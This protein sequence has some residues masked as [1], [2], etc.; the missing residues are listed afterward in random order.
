MDRCTYVAEKNDVICPICLDSWVEKDPRILQ[1]QHIFC[2]T[3]LKKLSIE[4]NTLYCPLCRQL[5]FIPEGKVKN[6]QKM[7]VHFSKQMINYENF[8]E[9]HHEICNFCCLTH[10]IEKI[11]KKC[12]DE[13][14]K[15]CKIITIEE[16]YMKSIMISKFLQKESKLK[17]QLFENIQQDKENLLEKIN[18]KIKQIENLINNVFQHRENQFHDIMKKDNS[19]LGK[20]DIDE[21]LTTNFN[22][23]IPKIEFNFELD[24]LDF[25]DKLFIEHLKCLK[26]NYIITFDDFCEEETSESF[27]RVRF[28]KNNL[29]NNSSIIVQIKNSSYGFKLHHISDFFEKFRFVEEFHLVGEEFSKIECTKLC[30]NLSL[31]WKTLKKLSIQNCNV[32]KFFSRKITNLL[33][34]CCSLEEIN[35]SKNESIGDGLLHILIGLRESSSNLTKINLSYCELNECHINEIGKLLQICDKIEFI[36]LNSNYHIDKTLSVICYGLTKSLKTLKKVEFFDCNLSERQKTNL[37]C[38]F[39]NIIVY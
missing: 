12:I 2:F 18:K 37:K 22:L 25:Y 15:G 17:L 21:F 16:K 9:K 4:N 23:K 35:L 34:T 11:C 33:K 31:S 6:I 32:D 38:I 39:E 28:Q 1:C 24:Y 7:L 8:C 10:D 20:F 3:C 29:F 19:I 27:L 30:K 14:H 5:H 36:S 13:D 26:Y